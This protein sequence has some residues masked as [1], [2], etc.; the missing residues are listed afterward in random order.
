MMNIYSYGLNGSGGINVGASMQRFPQ[1]NITSKRGGIS[2][3]NLMG[4]NERNQHTGF[5]FTLINVQIP[6]IK[7]M[8]GKAIQM[9]I[10]TLW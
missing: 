8:T 3:L 4:K 10:L 2:M 6:Y 5:D 9:L 1:V 7:N